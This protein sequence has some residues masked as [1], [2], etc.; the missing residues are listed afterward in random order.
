MTQEGVQDLPLKL[1]LSNC[2]FI[3]LLMSGGKTLWRA[4]LSN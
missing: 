4:S 2:K 1:K 3:Q